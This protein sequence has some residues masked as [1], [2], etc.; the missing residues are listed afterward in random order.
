MTHERRQDAVRAGNGVRAMEDVRT[1]RRAAQ[2]RRRRAYSVLRRLVP[3]HGLRATHVARVAA[4]HRGLPRCQSVQAVSHGPVGTA[5]AFDAGRRAEHPRLAH[6]PRPG[7]TVDRA[8][9]HP[10]LAGAL[11][12]RPRRHRLCVGL[13]HHRSLLESVRPGSLSI[14]RGGRQAAHTA[15]SARAPFQRSFTPATASCTT[16]TCSTSRR[17]RPGPST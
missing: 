11:G 4:R 17:S 5:R 3:S 6:L 8:R 7:S 16:S 14:D 10:V 13:H 9:P 15:G 1:H 12:A 2:G